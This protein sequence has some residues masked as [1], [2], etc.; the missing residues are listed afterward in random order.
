M[1]P[2]HERPVD[3]T[4]A[5]VLARGESFEYR[6]LVSEVCS[7]LP[8]PT[9]PV[10]AEVEDMTGIKF[11]RLLVV[12]LH[13]G[14]KKR[15]VCR[16]ACGNYVMRRIAAIKGAAPDSA[17]PQC[18]LMAVSKRHEFIRRTGQQRHTREFLV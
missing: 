14:T 17:C 12:G 2:G 8:L 7:A 6:Q 11:G 15:W 10:P 4:A 16:C 5:R 13:E 9:R 1:K 18:Y 3:A